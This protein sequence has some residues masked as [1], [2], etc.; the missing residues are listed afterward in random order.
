LVTITRS[1][2]ARIRFAHRYSFEPGLDGGQLRVSVNGAPFRPVPAEAFTQNG[3]TG[4]I[5]G[6]G[7]LYEQ[8]AFN[9]DSP[10]YLE[11]ENATS[12]A[13]LGYVTT[14]DTLAVRFVGGWDFDVKGASPNWLLKSLILTEGNPGWPAATLFI[15]AH[16]SLEGADSPLSYQWQRDSGAGFVDIVGA[17]GDEYTFVPALADNGSRFRCRLY[18]GSTAT[19]AVVTLTIVLPALSIARTAGNIVLSWPGEGV[20]QEANSISG[21]WTE[22]PGTSNPRIVPAPLTNRFYR[23]RGM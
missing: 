12:I 11:D 7:P 16:A 3:Y 4:A 9:G 19:S 23:V 14:H 15:Q 21:P 13:D 17:N 8:T 18:G 2:S 20:L 5:G 22:V 1:G 6:I 10:G